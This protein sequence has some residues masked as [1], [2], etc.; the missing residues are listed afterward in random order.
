MKNPFHKVEIYRGEEKRLYWRIR[1]ANNRIVAVSGEGYGKPSGARD[2]VN[3]LI[4]SVS[5]HRKV[6]IVYLAPVK[7]PRARR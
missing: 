5:S 6:E 7:E 3:S 1:A 4:S 2:A